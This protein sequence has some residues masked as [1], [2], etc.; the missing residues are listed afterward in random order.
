[1]EHERTGQ[2]KNQEGNGVVCA[3]FLWCVVLY[4]NECVVDCVSIKGQAGKSKTNR[5]IRIKYT[6]G[7]ENWTKGKV[8]IYT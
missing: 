8:R 4:V 1:M 2:T 5:F 3:V 6:D 7:E